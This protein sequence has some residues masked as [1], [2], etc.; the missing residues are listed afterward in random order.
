MHR[1]WTAIDDHD[2]ATIFYSQ[3]AA[4]RAKTSESKVAVVYGSTYIYDAAV[5]GSPAATDPTGN[6]FNVD[7]QF[8]STQDAAEGPQGETCTVWN[9]TFAVQ[10]QGGGLRIT[11]SHPTGDASQQYAA[12]PTGFNT[13]GQ[14]LL[15]PDDA[16]LAQ[17]L[18]GGH[19][20]GMQV[21]GETGYLQYRTYV[22]CNLSP[23]T[24]PCDQQ[25]NDTIT[26][27]GN[28]VVGLTGAHTTNGT[29][30]GTLTVLTSDDPKLPSSVPFQIVDHVMIT[31]A[32]AANL[33]QA[34]APENSCGA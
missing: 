9:L 19:G 11:G 32:L 20:R 12:C 25:T 21:I 16:L 6:D 27:G 18:W 5:L 15:V 10:W 3:G 14:P 33:C 13:E 4:Q 30:G 34:G 24:F 29:Y 23:G 1:Y 22:F 7:V 8:V 28:A 31:N 2:W 26:D 17:G